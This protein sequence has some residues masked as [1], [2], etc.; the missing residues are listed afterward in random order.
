MIKKLM[1][2]FLVVVLVANIIGCF[3]VKSNDNSKILAEATKDSTLTDK[4][5]IQLIETIL[6]LPAV[7]KFS[8][9][10][11]IR[12]NQ[13]EIH[14][15]LKPDEFDSIPNITQNG[16]RLSILHRIDSLKMSEQPC[17]VFPKMEIK[18]DTANVQM[19]LDITGL[20]TNGKLYYVNGKWVPDK[21]FVVGVR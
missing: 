5:K 2:I 9:F 18:G 19:V 15:L 14:L 17:Y 10:E 4:K 3:N 6:N 1:K 7:I 11:I 8:K 20:I 13:I 12:R 16:Y 21:K